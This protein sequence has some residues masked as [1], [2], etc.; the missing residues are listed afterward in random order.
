MMT[1]NSSNEQVKRQCY[2]D[3][4]KARRHSETKVDVVAKALAL[5]FCLPL[6]FAACTTS[7]IPDLDAYERLKQ[8]SIASPEG[9]GSVALRPGRVEAPAMPGRLIVKISSRE[10][11]KRYHPGNEPAIDPKHNLFE[12]IGRVTQVT[13]LGRSRSGGAVFQVQLTDPQAAREI[14]ARLRDSGLALRRDYGWPTSANSSVRGFVAEAGTLHQGDR[15]GSRRY[16]QLKPESRL[17]SMFQSL[18]VGSIRRVFRMAERPNKG[19]LEVAATKDLL[20]EAGKRYPVRSARGYPNAAVPEGM[21]NWFLLR[22]DRDADLEKT[23]VA[24]LRAAGVEAVLFDYSVVYHQTPQSEPQYA[25]QWALQ[26]TAQGINVLPAWNLTGV[27]ARPTRVAVIDSG[28]KEN[29]DEFA[30]RIWNKSCLAGQVPASDHCEIPGNGIDDDLNGYVDDVTGITTNNEYPWVSG[31]GGL[32]VVA[33]EHAT[34]VAGVIAANSTNSTLIAGVAGAAPISIMNISL[35]D[36]AGCTELAEAILY[37]TLEGADVAN[38]SLGAPNHELT[39]QA[40]QAALTRNGGGVTLVASA[41]NSNRRVTDNYVLSGAQYPAWYRG[42]IAVGGT[43]SSGRRWV[44]GPGA[45]S[46]YGAG[47]ALVAPAKDVT[48]VTYPA[49]GTTAVLSS[50]TGT[51]ASAALVSGAAALILSYYP[52]VRVERMASWLRATATDVLDPEGTG[53]N[54]VGDDPYTGAGIVNAGSAATRGQPDPVVADIMMERIRY[55]GT[56]SGFVSNGVIGRP[57]LGITV[58]GPVVTWRLDYGLGDWPSSWIPVTLPSSVT[59][60]SLDVPRTAG[61]EVLAAAPG[62]NYLDT[63]NLANRQVYTLRLQATDALGLTYTAYDR[64]MPLRAMLQE[65]RKNDAV[66]VHWHWPNTWGVIDIRPGSTYKVEVLDAAGVPSPG[67]TV[68]PISAGSIQ[69]SRRTAVWAILASPEP[70]SSSNMIVAYAS[71]GWWSQPPAFSAPPSG[72]GQRTMRL[73]VTSP[74]GLITQDTQ[75]IYFDDTTFAVRSGWPKPIPPRESSRG[76]WPRGLGAAKMTGAGDYRLFVHTDNH[77]VSLRPDG[78][79]L[80]DKPLQIEQDLNAEDQ[81]FGPS[82]LIDDLDGDGIKEILVAGIVTTPTSTGS[83]QE[84]QLQLLKAD[85]TSYNSNWPRTSPYSGF[86]DW[87]LYG[88][89]HAADVDGDGIKE[90]IF[91][92]RTHPTTTAA[93]GSAAGAKVHVVDLNG[94]PKPGAWPVEVGGHWAALQVGDLDGDGRAEILVDNARLLGGTG[95]AR[96][97]WPA[98][99]GV[100]NTSENGGFQL[101]KLDPAASVRQVLAYDVVTFPGSFD[102]VFAVN[103][104]NADG[105]Q[106]PGSWP[107]YLERPTLRTDAWYDTTSRIYA[108]TAQVVAGGLQEVVLCYDKIRTLLAD[109]TLHP[110]RPA[111]DLN[112]QC[113]GLDIVD[114]DGD[115]Q[116]EYVALVARFE[117]DDGWQREAHAELEAYRLDG[118]PLSATDP[119]WPIRVTAA[120][121]FMALGNSVALVDLDGDGGLDFV[122]SLFFRPN[123]LSSTGVGFGIRD[124]LIEVLTIR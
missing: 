101:I 6:C 102:Q 37:A 57:N 55:W 74:G 112:G 110:T 86:G 67:W 29:L 54:L 28:I 30:G 2:A 93:A 78:T 53:A 104:R 106:Y 64:F 35:A 84:I 73:T 85:G 38:M 69:N 41:G 22:L 47:L 60:N 36:G 34:K 124:N 51:S 49:V 18:G 70:V 111:I 90:I 44:D 39:W 105:S 31:A 83:V 88:K 45:G 81:R 27:S 56:Y 46:N 72:Q 26:S 19:M 24:L 96:A 10:T 66:P 77:F 52:N 42:V 71:G 5:S 80:W 65:P 12:G 16:P 92:E 117:D 50:M 40:I 21:E 7:R 99:G 91:V 114:V 9:R 123:Q 3:L 89:L 4:K 109:G 122:Q 94:Q 58:T 23:R 115:G 100:N 8:P 11:L 79:I 61:P 116:M 118:T 120:H 63:D 87:T 113:R 20:V 43:D 76:S 95:L 82:F 32:P 59:S 68:G 48:T 108:K 33:T 103:V 119:R 121:T 107:V 15:K 25:S 13:E 98:T 62:H 97:G 17:N 14:E 75:P 1:H